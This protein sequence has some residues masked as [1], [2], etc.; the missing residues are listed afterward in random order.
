MAMADAGLEI[1]IADNGKGID[2]EIS[3]DGHGLKNLS[4]RLQKLGGTCKIESRTEGGTVVKFS[5]P[6]TGI[7]NASLG[8]ANKS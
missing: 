2:D 1:D 3:G 6:L 7:E 4:T 5:L 8:Q